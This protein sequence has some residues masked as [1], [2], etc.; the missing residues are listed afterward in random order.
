VFKFALS[1]ERGVEYTAFMDRE[2]KN[3]QAELD[4]KMGEVSGLLSASTADIAAIREALELLKRSSNSTF[5]GTIVFDAIQKFETAIE[6]IEVKTVHYEG[7]ILGILDRI[8]HN[9]PTPT[10]ISRSSAVQFTGESI[11]MANNALTLNVGQSAQASPVTFLADGV[12]PSGATYSASTYTF[13][14]PSA[15][16]TLNSDGVT[17][18]VAGVATSTGPINGSV[19]FT[20]TDTDGAVSTWTQPFTVQTG[21]VAPPPPSQ[22]SQSS[23]LQFSTPA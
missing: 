11:T 23:A 7:Q 1:R 18:T 12:T 20:A 19:S 21:T 4:A 6:R 8:R 9:L 22:L 10:T 5:P 3:L 17:A 2:P 13:S 15:T 14:D 16:V